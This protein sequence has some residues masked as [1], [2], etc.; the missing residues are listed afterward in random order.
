[1]DPEGTS[2]RDRPSNPKSNERQ[3]EAPERMAIF[4][5]T[6]AMTE[7]NMTNSTNELHKGTGC[8]QVR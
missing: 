2:S 5:R 6:G 1:M 4:Q 3:T 7:T 8:W